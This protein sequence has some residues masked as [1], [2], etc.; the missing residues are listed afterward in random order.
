MNEVSIVTELRR[1]AAVRA[2]GVFP[3]EN[4]H[5]HPGEG[6]ASSL[7][8][9]CDRCTGYRETGTGQQSGHEC[10]FDSQ[11]CLERPAA[12]LE[13]ACLDRFMAAPL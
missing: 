5:V 9:V 7:L 4:V 1:S 12:R 13:E 2:K 11:P 8:D 10:F 3:K 6:K